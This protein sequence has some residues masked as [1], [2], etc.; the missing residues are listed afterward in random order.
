MGK[1]HGATYFIIGILV[2]V[3]SYYL[4]NKRGSDS[5]ILF[6][7]IGVL[8][9]I[10]GLI[11]LVALAIKKKDEH[12]KPPRHQQQQKSHHQQV[13]HTPQFCQRC[14]AALRQTD[15]FCAMCGNALYNLRS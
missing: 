14:G 15:H 12:P 11:K 10:I 5:F 2:A 8:F 4:D 6:F 13:H 9:V 1:I 3:F 7:Y